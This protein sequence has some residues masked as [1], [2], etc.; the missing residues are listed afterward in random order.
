[1]KKYYYITTYVQSKGDKK[2]LEENG[3]KEYMKPK[4]KYELVFVSRTRKRQQEALKI[5]EEMGLKTIKGE[6]RD[7]S[8]IATLKSASDI[9][10]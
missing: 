6:R 5:T 10:D 4:G 9:R 3:F 1:M 7:E 2:K 8:Y